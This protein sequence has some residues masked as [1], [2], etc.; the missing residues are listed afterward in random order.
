MIGRIVG[1]P[2]VTDQTTRS[3]FSA[4]NALSS[5]GPDSR[6]VSDQ[7]ENLPYLIDTFEESKM[8]IFH[9]TKKSRSLPT[10]SRSI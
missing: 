9:T 7:L 3:I 5:G 1:H 2:L 4:A 10:V 6:R 8:T